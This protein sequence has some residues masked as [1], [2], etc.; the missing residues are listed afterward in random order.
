VKNSYKTLI[1]LSPIMNLPPELE[2]V[3]TVV[4]FPLPDETDFAQLLD[5]ILEEVKDQPNIKINISPEAREQLL[6]AA[7]G[8]TLNEAENV[9]AKILVN[10]ARIT[11]DDIDSVYSEKKQIIRKSGLLDYYESEE[12]FEHVGGL[13]NLKD[14]LRRRAKAFTDK[15]KDYGLPAPRGV[16]LLGVQGCGKSLCA[17]AVSSLWRMPLIRLDVGRMFGS[18]VGSSE[19]KHAQGPSGG[20]IGS[21]RGAVAR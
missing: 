21:P 19:E 18:L 10:D 5:R 20:G 3:V 8:L 7:L 9:F 13:E 12:R 17:K 14:W 2:K 16:F 11:E 1:L 15:A 6:K 4:D